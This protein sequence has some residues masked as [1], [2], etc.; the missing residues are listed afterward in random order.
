MLRLSRLATAL[1]FLL[2]FSGTAARAQSDGVKIEFTF[3]GAVDC[4]QPIKVNNFGFSGRGSGILYANRRAALDVTFSG[5]STNTIRF[6]ASLGG[7]PTSAPGGT[8]QL[9][10]LGP[11]KLRMIWSLPNNDQS[12][13]IAV[14]GRSC[15]ASI[16]NTLKRGSRQYSL[17]DGGIFIFC[18]K[19]RITQTTCNIR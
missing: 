2:T 17:F 8:A 12:V 19:P 11:N 18:A 14:S 15:T 9:R 7:A 13:D 1:C 6:D 5:V 4:E 3:Q 10:V 16:N